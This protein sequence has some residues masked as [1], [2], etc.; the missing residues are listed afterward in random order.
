MRL[1]IFFF[2]LV[3]LAA[4]TTPAVAADFL[5]LSDIHFD[6]LADASLV[7]KLAA[8]EPAQWAGI[9]AS[10]SQK[11]PAYGHDTNWALLSSVLEAAGK[12]DPKA[13]FTIVTGDLLVHHFREQFNAAATKHD[14]AAFRSFVS[15]SIQFVALELKQGTKPVFV[16]LGNND[17]ECGDYSVQPDGAFLQDSAPSVANLAGLSDTSSYLHSGNYA[18]ANPSVKHARIVVLNTVFFSRRYNNRC[19]TAGVDP[20]AETLNWLD[21]QLASAQA[22]HEKVWLVYHIPPGIDAF[23]S[24]HA[25]PPGSGT[26]LWK[27]PYLTKFLDLLNRYPGVANVN[28]AGHI[29]VDDFRLL[30][31]SAFL[32]VCPAVSP[33]TGQNPTFRTVTFDGHG[34]LQ[35]Q[36]TYYINNLAAPKWQLE[37]DFAKTWRLRGLNAKNYSTLFSRF[38]ADA[39]TTSRWLTLYSTSHAAASLTPETFRPYYCAETG[40][41][42]DSYQSCLQRR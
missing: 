7:D 35:N 24:T 1:A 17:D 3:L 12:T 5:W 4:T 27:A 15:K 13:A 2:L 23:A 31:N 16:A 11:F 42:A 19:G 25:N 28:L 20:G 10:G 34:N 40:L 33:I 39:K 32:V 21:Q 37:Y 6:P 26:P 8:A 41:S 38:G 18:V 29:H 30:N 9:F 22:K 36:S 14:D